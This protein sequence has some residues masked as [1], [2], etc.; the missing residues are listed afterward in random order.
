MSS[1]DNTLS[2]QPN[3]SGSSSPTPVSDAAKTIYNKASEYKVVQYAIDHVQPLIPDVV[4]SKAEQ[5][6]KPALDIADEQVLKALAALNILRQRQSIVQQQWYKNVDDAL[7][8]HPRVQNS[9]EQVNSIIQKLNDTYTQLYTAGKQFD[10]QQFVDTL[11]TKLGSLY[12]EQLLQPAQQFYQRVSTTVQSTQSGTGSPRTL[13]RVLG[14]ARSTLGHQWENSINSALGQRIIN[15]AQQLYDNALDTYVKLKDNPS[16]TAN[17]FI[18]KMKL[19]LNEQYTD[20]LEQPLT[21]FYNKAST[22]S[23]DQ[24][25]AL[26]EGVDYDR[27]GEISL[28]DLIHSSRA[29]INWANNTVSHKWGSVLKSTQD[30]IDKIIPPVSDD[31]IATAATTTSPKSLNTDTQ[32]STEYS[33]RGLAGH[34]TQRVYDHVTDRVT[35]VQTAVTDHASKRYEQ[36]KDISS[37]TVAPRT[38]LDPVAILESLYNRITGRI[39]KVQTQ[40]TQSIDQVRTSLEQLQQQIQQRLD[41]IKQ[42]AVHT[43]KIDQI[44]NNITNVKNEATAVVS[45]HADQYGVTQRL[46]VLQ[47]KVSDTLDALKSLGSESSQ[48]VLNRQLT[49]LPADVF[50]FLTHSPALLIAFF[51]NNKQ[52]TSSTTANSTSSNQLQSDSATSQSDDELE[53]LIQKVEDVLL[54]LKHLFLLT[55]S[56]QKQEQQAQQA[57][58]QQNATTTTTATTKPKTKV[59]HTLPKQAN[60]TTTTRSNPAATANDKKSN[61]AA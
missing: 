3:N 15:D 21:E 31:N 51:Y 53:Q 8:S 1:V 6:G 29:V 42:Q 23:K 32:E 61:G 57:A 12:T 33:V 55:P 48:F 14:S 47:S 44:Q 60:I 50:Y 27:N 43:T 13:Q 58:Q 38:G 18:N 25:T 28:N 56:Q 7:K 2:H 9:V 36:V 46:T 24:L 5:Y 17:D 20:K 34:V 54:A 40:T 45:K 37:N 41:I 22:Y 19:N 59:H 11:K 49:K 26:Y 16:A 52:V 10:Q 39:H 30:Q 35:A 4:S